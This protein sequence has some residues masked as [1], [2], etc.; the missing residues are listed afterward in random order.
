M[1][2]ELPTLIDA[3]MMSCWRGCGKKFENE[4]MKHLRP[5]G[6]SIDLH[7]GGCFAVAQET[8]ERCVW[9][10]D[11]SVEDALL[12]GQG[13]FLKAWGD[14]QIPEH[15]ET[16]KTYDNV[17]RAVEA[18]YK[19]WPPRSDWIIPYKT[20]DGKRTFEYTFA[21]PLEPT[22]P[23]GVRQKP[24][25]FPLHPSGIPFLY[26]GRFDKL[27]FNVHTDKPTPMDTKTGK[28]IGS[29]WAEQWTLRSQFIGYVWALQQHGIDAS[30]MLVRGVA[31]LKRD[32]PKLEEAL[33][34]YSEVL[35][36]RWHEQLRR[37]L[38]R[39]VEQYNEGY[40]DYDLGDH[41]THFGSC[42]F[43]SSCSSRDPSIWLAQFEPR[44]WNPL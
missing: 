42:V 33:I 10:R 29:L 8:I 37:D 9:E 15:K 11:L 28:G 16:P 43:L 22:L 30:D 4:F 39:M 13:A 2:L 27:G 41:C 3:T 44:V 23:K 38:W 21:I 14:F 34:P 1:A 19:R 40:F 35:V 32:E 5:P 26:G 20:E 7:A 24:G 12:Y 31:I 25:Y 18:Y 36:A 17:W 6:L